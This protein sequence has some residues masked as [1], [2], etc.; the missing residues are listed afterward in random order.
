MREENNIKILYYGIGESA[1]VKNIDKFKTS[2]FERKIKLKDNIISFYDTFKININRYKVTFIDLT[3]TNKYAVVDIFKDEINEYDN[4]IILGDDNDFTEGI[5]KSLSYKNIKFIN[6]IIN[7]ETIKRSN[8]AN[9]KIISKEMIEFYINKLLNRDEI[10]EGRV[11]ISQE[12]PIKRCGIGVY[13]VLSE[14]K[15]LYSQKEVALNII[16]GEKLYLDTLAYITDPILEYINEN[17][18]VKVKNIV[19]KELNEN[20]IVN[21]LGVQ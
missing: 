9:K 17:A 8:I 4:I 11:Y 19:S 2:N 15:E 12:T 14:C 1:I 3:R 16:S 10:F 18:K 13:N 21:I 6:I 7:E 5:N 20:F